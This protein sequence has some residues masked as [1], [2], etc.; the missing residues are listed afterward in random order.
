MK[1]TNRYTEAIL[2][3]SPCSTMRETLEKAVLKGANLKGAN[4]K[5]ANLEGANLKG[6]NLK[7][8]N[9][10]GANLEGANLEGANLE[11]AYLKGVYLEGGN[12][13]TVRADFLAAVLN[14]P[15]ELEFLRDTIKAGKVNGSTYSGECACLAGTLAH[16]KGIECYTGEPIKN[17]RTFIADSSSPRECFFLAI[18]E[19]D[20][21][22]NNVAS[23]LALEWTEEAIA[24]RD[25]IRATAPKL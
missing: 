3:E 1:I 18:K 17:G 23:K 21:P 2:W 24:I 7:G 22:K 14:L 25:N 15:N 6:A 16:A 12:L 9:L 10:E 8:A 19:G 20:T 5:G 4:L 13:P 11:G